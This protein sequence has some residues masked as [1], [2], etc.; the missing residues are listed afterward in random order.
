M[1]GSIGGR[2][3]CSHGWLFSV[4][5]VVAKEGQIGLS[6]SR[7]HFSAKVIGGPSRPGFCTIPRE[8]SW[9]P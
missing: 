7:E 3:E 1:R 6:R 4:D 5:E 2:R 9:W 8:V